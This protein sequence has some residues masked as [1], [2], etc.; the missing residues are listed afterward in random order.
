MALVSCG[1]LVEG[2]HTL[3]G[4]DD[5]MIFRVFT[6]VSV[7]SWYFMSRVREPEPTPVTP[8]KGR[9]EGWLLVRALCPTLILSFGA[10]LTIPFMSL[11]FESVFG[12][13]SNEFGRLGAGTGL[14]IM[15]GAL[16]NPTIKRRFGWGTAIVGMQIVAIV[17]L[18]GLALT[19]FWNSAVWALPLACTLYVLRQP[20]MNMTGPLS[21]ELVMSYVGPRNRE[22]LA[23]MQTGVWN[24]SW[25]LSARLFSE[26]RSLG[27]PYGR[28]FLVTA[29]LY[30]VSTTLMG[31]LILDWR[32]RR[33]AGLIETESLSLE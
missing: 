33:D 21:S 5:P 15:A 14:L 6:I 8:R 24:G 11:F 16:V 3:V 7:L 2:L 19:D 17:M 28:V 4:F 31:F 23:A 13:T 9:F 1:F 18:V 10:G 29:G 26:M 20:L 30:A 12:F 22:M 32:R 25:F 27:W